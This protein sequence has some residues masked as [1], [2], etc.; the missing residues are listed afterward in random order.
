MATTTATTSSAPERI[1]P[2]KLPHIPGRTRK[3]FITSDLHFFHTKII[4][5]A[6]RPYHVE[7]WSNNNPVNASVIS[8][9]NEDILKLFDELPLDCDIWNLGDLFV[10]SEREEKPEKIQL[11]K[12]MVTRMKGVDNRRR[13][14]LV[15]GN[16]DKSGIDF[17][18][19][20]GFDGVYDTPVVLEDK[21]ILSHEP[22]FLEKGSPMI[23]IFGHLHDQ[24]LQKTDFCI[25]YKKSKKLLKKAMRG[26]AEKPE[27]EIAW[28]E[29]EVDLANYRNV[30][31]DYNKG[32]LEWC[33]DVFTVASPIWNE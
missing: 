25:D 10:T 32:I 1:D 5:Y 6:K 31:L 15:L 13:L 8:Q 17:Y 3:T 19:N 16:H 26:E 18:L 22:M 12:S 24:V 7:G 2:E 23:N 14:F 4:K 29:R 27:L 30:C 11:M 21:Y 28:P 20:L 33:G 9:M